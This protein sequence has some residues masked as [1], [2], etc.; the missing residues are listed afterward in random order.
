MWT[1]D[2][3]TALLNAIATGALRV[4][5]AD[6]EVEYRSLA[7]MQALLQQMA[8]ALGITKPTTRTTVASYESGL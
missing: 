2:H 1:M 5:Y 8:V 4:K 7:E 6:K 3:Y